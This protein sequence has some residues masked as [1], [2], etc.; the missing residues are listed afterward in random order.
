MV[1]PVV[2][3][4]VCILLVALLAV[5]CAVVAL[6]LAV[7]AV[8]CAIADDDTALSAVVCA[9][10]AASDVF[11]ISVGKSLFMLEKL[12]SNAFMAV[13]VHPIATISDR[14]RNLDI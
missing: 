4:A 10:V 13:C 14:V 1:W 9:A 11:P 6:E 12:C 8:V 7:L 2:G 3:D 5:V